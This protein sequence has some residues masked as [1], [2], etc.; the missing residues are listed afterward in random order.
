[1]LELFH[2]SKY[3][4]FWILFIQLNIL[5]RLKVA[6]ILVLLKLSRTTKKW[7]LL[8]WI[9]SML[10]INRYMYFRYFDRSCHLNLPQAP[11]WYLMDP[12]KS[13]K[14]HFL[15]W[16]VLHASTYSILRLIHLV[17]RSCKASIPSWKNEAY[18]LLKITIY[19]VDFF[20]A[21]WNSSIWK[22]FKNFRIDTTS[23]TLSVTH[24]VDVAKIS[25]ISWIRWCIVVNFFRSD[26]SVKIL[27]RQYTIR[28]L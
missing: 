7:A 17:K 15:F 18:L 12:T 24:V 4:M 6:S 13:M 26:S 14:T 16:K 22:H 9:H 19:G 11:G 8:E 2:V 27:Y 23:M 10:I 21:R 3:Q 5:T 20:A 28:L 1:M 25:C